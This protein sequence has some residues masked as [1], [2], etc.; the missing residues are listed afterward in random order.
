MKKSIL[1][2]TALLFLQFSGAQAMRVFRKLKQAPYAKSS[3][4]SLSENFEGAYA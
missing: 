1:A 4:H 3:I 2:V